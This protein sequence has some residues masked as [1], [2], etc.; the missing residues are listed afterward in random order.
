MDFT[1]LREITILK[2]LNHE[3]I[4]KLCDMF[5]STNNLFIAYEFIDNDISH[6]IHNK[7]ITMTEGVIKGLLYQL[8][9]GLSEIHKFHVVHRDLKPQNLLLSKFGELKIAD[10]GFARIIAS[11]ERKMTTGVVSEWYRP[12]EIFFGAEFYAYSVDIWSTGCIFAE[13]LQKEP[14]FYGQNERE[15]L[16]KIFYLLGI[17]TVNIP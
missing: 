16:T 6:I 17:P 1:A 9:L 11:P 14:L 7:E 8:L 4:V 12:P 2:E 3:N 15:I 13:F 5:Y 10:F